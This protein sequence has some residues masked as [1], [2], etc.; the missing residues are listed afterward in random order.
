MTLWNLHEIL[1]GDL[2]LSPNEEL[3]IVHTW[4]GAICGDGVCAPREVEDMN[5]EMGTTCEQDCA[6]MF[7]GF[8]SK[9][10][11]RVRQTLLVCT[12]LNHDAVQHGEQ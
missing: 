6:P 10:S 4:A 12:R 1:K 2:A 5:G 9:S 11:E 3:S 8:C 7:S